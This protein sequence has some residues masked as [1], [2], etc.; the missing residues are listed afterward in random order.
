VV[1]ADSYRLPRL[2][3]IVVLAS[4]FELVA[5]R[6]LL[7][8]RRMSGW[9]AASLVWWFFAIILHSWTVAIVGAV[10]LAVVVLVWWAEQRRYHV[11]EIE[12]TDS[13]SGSEFEGW[14]EVFFSRLGFDCERTGRAG[15]FG[16]DL[17]I[18][19][20]GVRTA[21]QAKRTHFR[22]GVSA[23]QQVAAARAYYDC[24]RAMVVTNQYFTNHAFLLA[25]KTGVV[26]RSRDDLTRKL[27]ELRTSGS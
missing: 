22:V 23:V 15:D 2:R 5:K 9:T 20:N 7:D 27:F 16:A 25:E 17:I 10:L 24:E 11:A 13:L 8:V 4:R 21:V 1:F 18:S 12:E 19:W 26:L 14:L 3:R 6:V